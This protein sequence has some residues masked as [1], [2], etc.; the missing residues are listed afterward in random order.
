MQCNR[1]KERILAAA[2]LNLR[3]VAYDRDSLEATERNTAMKPLWWEAEQAQRESGIQVTV[4][5]PVN[6]G[7][8]EVSR[9]SELFSYVSECKSFTVYTPPNRFSSHSKHK[10]S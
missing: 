5:A 6:Q 10:D 2:F 4:S 8:C 9:M 3:N 7:S 1:W